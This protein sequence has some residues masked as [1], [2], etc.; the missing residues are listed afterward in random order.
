[1]NPFFPQQLMQGCGGCFERQTRIGDE[2]PGWQWAPPVKGLEQQVG[3]R[4][5]SQHLKPLSDLRPEA[6]M[7]TARERVYHHPTPDGH[8]W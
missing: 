1:M 7:A 8:R 5:V 4:A 3:G 2:R 6:P